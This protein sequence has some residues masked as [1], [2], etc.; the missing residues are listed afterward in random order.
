MWAT[1]KHPNNFPRYNFSWVILPFVASHLSAI[2][3]SDPGRW[4][5]AS[6]DSCRG[7][8]RGTSDPA[9]AS[10]KAPRDG[11]EKR[12]P[13]EIWHE[14]WSTDFYGSLHHSHPYNTY[15][16]FHELLTFSELLVV[17]A[18]IRDECGFHF[19]HGTVQFFDHIRTNFRGS[20]RLF[21]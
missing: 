4:A 19:Q 20:M 14:C 16:K 8:W 11:D 1:G 15:L 17:N 7:W 21:V 12:L 3:A 13:M 2:P 18:L 5:R 6:F 10:W 9:R